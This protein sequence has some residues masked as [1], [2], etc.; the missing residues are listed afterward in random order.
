[1]HA[2]IALLFCV[3][4]GVMLKVQGLSALLWLP[5]GFV[6][7]LY[8]S[9]QIALPLMLGMPRATRLVA[10]GQMR[11]GV[12]IPLLVVPAIWAGAVFGALFLLGYFWP[13]VAAL[14]KANDAL[15]LGSWLGFVAIIL[16][17]L[18]RKSR[19]DFREDFERSYS[20]F[21]TV[22]TPSHT[23]NCTIVRQLPNHCVPACLESVAKDSGITSITQEGIVRQFPS[24][25]PNGVLNDLNKSPNLENV[26]R[27]LGLA[28]GI[29]RIQFQGIENLAELH[30]ENEILLM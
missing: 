6:I 21:Y 4:L 25:F 8:A 20:R 23:M 16:S 9:A 17:P 24:V 5:L 13:S 19:S 28:D 15:N 3:L 22:P 14:I 10:K 26:V 18:S 30:R 2:I 27:D 29:Y 7:S 11:A 1:M 12:F